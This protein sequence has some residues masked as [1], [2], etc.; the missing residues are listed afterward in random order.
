MDDAAHPAG[1]GEA[2]P[3]E[4]EPEDGDDAR[5]P[6][7]EAEGIV[8]PDPEFPPD[9][10][11]PSRTARFAWVAVIVLLVGVIALVVYALTGTPATQAAVRR[12]PAPT[13]LVASLGRV[14]QSVF[15]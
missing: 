1:P 2:P 14:P 15:D 13:A 11:P 9:D 4:P 10:E 12:T 6:V 3:T 8:E 7:E 5:G